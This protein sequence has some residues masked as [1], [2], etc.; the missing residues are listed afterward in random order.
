VRLRIYEFV[1]TVQQGPVV[2]SQEIPVGPAWQ[3]LSVDHTTLVAGS[4]LSMRITMSPTAANQSF[5]ADDASIQL[6]SG[7]GALLAA[8]LSDDASTPAAAPSGPRLLDVDAP[9]ALDAAEPWVARLEGIDAL[10][11]DGMPVVTL[12]H[13]AGDTPSR[14]LALGEDVDANGREEQVVAFDRAAIRAQLAGRTGIVDASIVV[15]RGEASVVI[16]VRLELA[17]EALVFSASF[18]PNPMRGEGALSFALT[19]P[20][21]V[22]VELYDPSGRRVRMLMDETAAQAG[23]Y[24]LSISATRGGVALSPGVYFYRVKAGEGI[25]SGRMVVVR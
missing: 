12:R 4:T 23:R 21:P 14:W 13:A 10:L 16:P 22:R 25:R 5:I 24:R 11:E 20:G 6:V 17:G 9:I 2:M 3:L 15:Q 7:G 1:G 8:D 19:R 18:G